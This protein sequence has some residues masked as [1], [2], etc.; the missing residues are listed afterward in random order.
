MLSNVMA[1]CCKEGFA[2][3]KNKKTTALMQLL[4]G[5]SLHKDGK[6]RSGSFVQRLGF[7]NSLKKGQE[8]FCLGIDFFL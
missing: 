4:T 6:Q 1:S 8:L 7:S 2:I 5:Q 3:N